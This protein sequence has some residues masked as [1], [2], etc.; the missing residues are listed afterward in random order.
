[1]K[2]WEAEILKIPE[3]GKRDF[4]IWVSWLK[5]ARKLQL[6]SVHVRG[7]LTKWRSNS[8]QAAECSA[9]FE[10]IFRRREKSRMCRSAFSSHA[11]Y[12]D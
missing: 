5:S 3:A 7:K 10:R 11:L 2:S 8:Q 6:G 9:P 12:R 1:L 4:F